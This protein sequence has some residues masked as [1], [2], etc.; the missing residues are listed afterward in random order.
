MGQKVEN[1]W[2]GLHQQQGTVIDWR[3]RLH[4]ADVSVDTTAPVMTGGEWTACK[5]ASGSSQG[6]AGAMLQTGAASWW[7]GLPTGLVNSDGVPLDFRA[8]LRTAVAAL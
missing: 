7:S 1:V 3:P 4:C 8:A 5:A 2:L 6:F